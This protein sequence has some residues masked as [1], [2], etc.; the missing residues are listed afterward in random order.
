MGTML[1]H[2]F[3]SEN[4]FYRGRWE[5]C[6]RHGEAEEHLQQVAPMNVVVGHAVALQHGFAE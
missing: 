4:S 6:V 1:G 5:A 3:L 2:E